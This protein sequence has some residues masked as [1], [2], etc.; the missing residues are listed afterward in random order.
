MKNLISFTKW[1]ALLSGMI[2]AAIVGF[3]HGSGTASDSVLIILSI[4][5]V[6]HIVLFYYLLLKS[7]NTSNHINSL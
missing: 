3:L 7:I 6:L 4:A 2:L 1:R 5:S